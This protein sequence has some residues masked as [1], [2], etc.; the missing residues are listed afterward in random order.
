ME[1][2]GLSTEE[3]IERALA[4]SDDDVCWSYVR[5]IHKRATSE[6]FEAAKNLCESEDSAKVVIGTWILGELGY[7]DKPFFEETVN[8]LVP[9]SRTE[10]DIEALQSITSTLGK[11]GGPA[12]LE[13]L[14]ELKNHEH[15]DIRYS[16]THGL[17]TI[18]S[19]DAI[20]AL[21]ELS[22]DDD[23]DVRNWATFGLGSQVETDTPEIREA[24]LARLNEDDAEIRGEALVGLAVRKD[25]RVVELLVKELT[26]KVVGTLAVEAAF[27]IGDERLYDAL[28]ALNDWW[29]VDEKLLTE[30][31]ENCRR[32]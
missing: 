13:R 17:L 12:A 4:E 2:E 9:L 24:L 29:D 26:G 5:A 8:L 31:I 23:E 7:P 27:E 25:K 14:L 1:N 15:E 20:G 3:L 22:H 30:A 21:L 6:T 32:K 16:V 11:I 19:D 10:I 18:E 28:I